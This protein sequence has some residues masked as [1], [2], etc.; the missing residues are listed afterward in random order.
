[1]TNTSPRTWHHSDIPDL[2]AG[3]SPIPLAF[4]QS[5]SRHP[6]SVAAIVSA[7][8][9]IA[10]AV[11]AHPRHIRRARL[12]FQICA[13]VQ[14]P[15]SLHVSRRTKFIELLTTL[16]TI[17]DDNGNLSPSIYVIENRSRSCLP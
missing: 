14:I 9:L 17:F 4:S 2:S 13:D 8:Q 7:Q 11:R 5:R 10:S 3:E 1:M 6:L 12:P 15:C 16:Y